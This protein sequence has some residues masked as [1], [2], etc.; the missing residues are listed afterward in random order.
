M[1]KKL[2]KIIGKTMPLVLY[3]SRSNFGSKLKS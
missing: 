1:D 3:D 2:N